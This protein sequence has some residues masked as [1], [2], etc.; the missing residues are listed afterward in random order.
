MPVDSGDLPV[1]VRGLPQ[2]KRAVLVVEGEGDMVSLLLACEVSGRA[3]LMADIQILPLDGTTNLQRAYV[4]HA[5][6]EQGGWPILAL[7]DS[8]EHGRKALTELKKRCF[9]KDQLLHYAE[10]FGSSAHGYPYEAEDLWGQGL[11]DLF[12]VLHDCDRET[13]RNGHRHYNLNQD[14]KQLLHEYLVRAARS[15]HAVRWIELAE[16]IRERLGLDAEA[17]VSADTQRSAQ[18][19]PEP[20]D[21]YD[22]RSQFTYAQLRSLAT[23]R[24]HSFRGRPTRERAVAVLRRQDGEGWKPGTLE[25]HSGAAAARVA[26]SWPTTDPDVD[27]IRGEIT[28][29]LRSK[30]C[31]E[32]SRADQPRHDAC[33]RVSEL[34]VLAA[35]IGEEATVD[36]DTPDF[37]GGP[38]VLLGYLEERKCATCRPLEEPLHPACRTAQ[39][40]AEQIKSLS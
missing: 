27:R 24:G 35:A 15:A 13:F 19:R 30:V 2:G 7:F 4:A 40:H 36:A 5:D 12:A 29:Y 37:A 10:L 1:T 34:S 38:A 6:A 21:G 33:R 22:D 31:A 8:D 11:M 14:Q 9:T 26:A 23:A 20:T 3:D 17:P 25:H 18:A 32:C 28:E 39:R 16:M